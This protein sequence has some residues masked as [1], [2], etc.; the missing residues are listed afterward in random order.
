MQYCSGLT[1]AIRRCTKSNW[2]G[3]KGQK[4]WIR[5]TTGGWSMHRINLYGWMSLNSGRTPHIL[6]SSFTLRTTSKTPKCI[7]GVWLIRHC[8]CVC[9]WQMWCNAEDGKIMQ[10]PNTQLAINLCSTISSLS[11]SF[12]LTHLDVIQMMAWSRRDLHNV[13]FFPVS[14]PETSEKPPNEHEHMTCSRNANLWVIVE[15]TNTICIPFRC[16]YVTPE[17]QPQQFVDFF[18]VLF[19]LWRIYLHFL[20]PG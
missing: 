12:S 20:V 2:Y 1:I 9:V 16:Q 11:L 17:R 10:I 18:F 19:D 8:V 7:H 4:I 15:C 5:V 14:W 3:E 13:P 6:C